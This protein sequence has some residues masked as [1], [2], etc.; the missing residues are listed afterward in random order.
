[1]GVTGCWSE[2]FA[3]VLYVGEV[4]LS[5]CCYDCQR[6]ILFMRFNWNKKMRPRDVD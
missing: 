6:N 3:V 4:E 2:S 5:K 1:M